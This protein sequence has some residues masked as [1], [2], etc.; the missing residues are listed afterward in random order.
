[1]LKYLNG[2]QKNFIEQLD[3]ILSKRKI[4]DTKKLKVVKKI[5]SDVIKNKDKA[6]LKYEKKFSKNKKLTINNIRFS[7]FES[8]KINIF[9]KVSG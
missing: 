5:I 8:I 4:T 1:M 2:D 7:D 3:H 9:S 6:L